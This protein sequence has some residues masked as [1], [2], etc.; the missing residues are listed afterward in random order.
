MIFFCKI[1]H[2]KSYDA[3]KGWTITSWK[4]NF[5]FYKYRWNPYYHL[6]DGIFSM[7]IGSSKTINHNMKYRRT[8]HVSWNKVIYYFFPK[9]NKI[10]KDECNRASKNIFLK[11]Q[12]NSSFEILNIKSIRTVLNVGCDVLRYCCCW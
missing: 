10:S 12:L 9:K 2:S 6:N 11:A 5:E 3:G 1:I 4:S 7:S 8:F